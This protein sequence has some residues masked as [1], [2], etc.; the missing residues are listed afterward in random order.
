MQELTTLKLVESMTKEYG[1][2]NRTCKSALIWVIAD[3]DEALREDARKLL[4]WAAISDEE[5][6]L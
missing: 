3:S 1:A 6:E 4:A 2:S 5:D